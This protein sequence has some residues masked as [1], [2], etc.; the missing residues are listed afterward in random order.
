[1]SK[2]REKGVCQEKNWRTGATVWYYREGQGKRVRLPGLFGSPEFNA[3][4]IAAKRS[5]LG[6][7]APAPV[8]A[9]LDPQ[10][11]ASFAWLV[12]QYVLSSTCLVKADIT[13]KTRR[14][15]LRRIAAMECG[16]EKV[17][18]QPYAEMEDTDI[19]KIRDRIAT[20]NETVPMEQVGKEVD[21]VVLGKAP[22]ASQAVAIM[23]VMFNWAV[24]IKKLLKRN[25]CLG[26]KGFK[27]EGGTNY[28]WTD[29]DML[30][31]E[32]AYPLGT[33]E[34]LAYALLLYSGQRSFDVKKM[35]RQHIKNDAGT[36]W[37][38][39]AKQ[40]KTKKGA[41][42]PVLP[43]LAEAINACPTS[44]LTFIADENGA[45]LKDFGRWF[46]AACDKAGVPEC[47]PHGLR[48]AGATRLADRGARASTLMK[49]YAFTLVQ[50]QT[51]I[52]TAENKRTTLEDIHLLNHVA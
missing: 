51:Y 40:H 30:K 42:V 37:L 46:R 36:D 28:V 12:E 47:T 22:M 33:R 11:P 45:P 32:E 9:K 29:A 5:A 24:D 10:D 35:G 1:M 49:I 16:S 19:R 31:F 8:K 43:V 17:G 7:S 6:V 21:G 15:V 26:V 50:A 34:R 2:R 3:A 25:P 23:R 13:M 44:G 27:Y 20:E 48:H 39:T 18:S 38:V 41:G 52:Q 4:L 14:N